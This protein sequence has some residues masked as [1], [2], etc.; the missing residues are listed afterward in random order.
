MKKIIC[1]VLVVCLVFSLA[2][3]RRNEKEPQGNN[4]ST[5]ENAS[6]E[7]VNNDQITENKAMVAVSVPAVTEDTTA[8]DGTVL[9]QYTY[10]HMSLVLNKPDVADKV[11]LDFLNRV[12][13][14]K[15]SADAAA[16]MAK[17][18]YSGSQ[19]WMPYLYHIIYSPTRIDHNVLSLSGSNEVF[20]GAPHPERTCV[21]ASYDLQTGD[22]LTLA[23]IMTKEATS[24]AFCN[25]VLDGLTELAEG[26]Y[27][28]ENYKDTVK[29]RFKVD[30][31][32]DEAWY[33]TQTGLCFYFSP[34]E[35]APY[36]SGVIT[37]EIPYE[38]LNGLL[39]EDY[40]PVKRNTP[41]GSIQ[42]ALF[43]TVDLDKLSHIA[44]IVTNAGGNMYMAQTDG[45]VQ[46]V[47]I[48]LTDK[49]AN[50]TVFAA[51]ALYAGDGIMIQTD[52]ATR[53]KMKLTYKNGSQTV[54]TTIG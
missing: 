25:L 50:Y 1:L 31:S 33:F 28:Y 22:V 42:I 38:K 43:N 27:L 9:F 15:E 12:D 23:S 40:H 45:Y 53:Q 5:G 35:I 11:I 24:D 48:L 10:Q 20:S 46:D 34:Y 52:E 14:T 8:N 39:H 26:D 13:T 16:A 4:S 17:A 18:A 3:C 30:P 47:R 7:T 21:S 41:Q 29:Q 6:Q 2:A 51:Y 37:V 19:N 54:T 32:T 44:E 36:A 49:T